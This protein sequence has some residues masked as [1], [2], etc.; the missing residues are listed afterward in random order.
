MW[1]HF[2]SRTEIYYLVLSLTYIRL[3][4]TCQLMGISPERLTYWVLLDVRLIQK[5]EPQRK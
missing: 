3:I 1:N 2:R 4:I 5:A